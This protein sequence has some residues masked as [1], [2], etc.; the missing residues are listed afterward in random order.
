MTT[1]TIV[2]RKTIVTLSSTRMLNLFEKG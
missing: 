2:D 1:I